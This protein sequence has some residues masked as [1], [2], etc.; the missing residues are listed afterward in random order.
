MPISLTKGQR[1]SLEKDTGKVYEKVIMGLGWDARPQP[2][3]GLLG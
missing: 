1:V 3:K 2:R